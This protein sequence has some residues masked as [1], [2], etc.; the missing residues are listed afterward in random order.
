[1]SRF[2]TRR[3][4][5]DAG[6]LFQTLLRS[7]WA[8][9]LGAMQAR[10]DMAC[11]SGNAGK[12]ERR[13]GLGLIGKGLDEESARRVVEAHYDDVLAYCRRHTPSPD[14]A[15]DA[16]QETFLRFVRSL[17]SYRDRGKPLAFL[18]TIARNVCADVYRRRGR[19]W[20]QLDEEIPAPEA[21]DESGV[22]EALNALS[23][24]QREV[25]ELRYDQ[26]LRVV[27]VARVLGVSRFAAARRISAALD[28]LKAEL[29]DV[30]N[31]Q[32]GAVP[33]RRQHATCNRRA[34]DDHRD[35]ESAVPS[36]TSKGERP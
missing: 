5:G 11:G 26:G 28:A 15:A 17:P 36:A 24:D 9:A 27:E 8:S 34:T 20:E 22:R 30:D 18:L 3:D 10:S 14:E 6:P 4:R 13:S 7:C 12:H 35:S 32:R 19:V 23:A 21:P 29:D 16:A 1:M 33:D 31:L 2:G 25:L